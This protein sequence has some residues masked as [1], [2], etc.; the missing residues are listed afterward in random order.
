MPIYFFFALATD[1]LTEEAQ[2]V[3][4]DELA[5]VAASYRLAVRVTG[6]AD[7]ATGTRLINDSLSASRAEYI[8][9]QLASRGVDRTMITT[10][11]EGGTGR[12]R[13]QEA[14]R[15]TKVELTL[16]DD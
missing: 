6:A 5:R 14:N 3:N 12:Y 13:P 10:V 8:A 2:H 15:Y 16:F 7:S 11:S 1:T 4:L 9:S